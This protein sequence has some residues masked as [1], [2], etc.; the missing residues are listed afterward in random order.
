MNLTSDS[1]KCWNIKWSSDI[2]KAST[3]ILCFWKVYHMFLTDF[4]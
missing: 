1:L 3:N 4:W 2:F